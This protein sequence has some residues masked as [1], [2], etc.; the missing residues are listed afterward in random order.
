MSKPTVYVLGSFD[1]G[2]GYNWAGQARPRPGHEWKL[3]CWLDSPWPGP[4]TEGH[5]VVLKHAGFGVTAIGWW[6]RQGDDV[7]MGCHTTIVV[8]ADI[9]PDELMKLAR[10]QVPWAFRVD[11]QIQPWCKSGG[12]A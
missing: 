11:V 3:R 7:R 12:E 8:F 2:V 4:Q 10:E 9:E 5:A 6:D 1:V